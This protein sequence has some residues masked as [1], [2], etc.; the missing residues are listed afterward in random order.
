MTTPFRFAPAPACR[1]PEKQ[2]TVL[3]RRASMAA[4]VVFLLLALSFPPAVQASS[5]IVF[6][7]FEGSNFGAWK[8]E[9]TAFGGGPAHGPVPPQGPVC[10]YLG[11]GF[12]DSFHGG[13]IATGTLTSPAFK[14]ERLHVSFLIGGGWEK[15]TRI[16]L[17][18]DG[19][20]ERSAVAMHGGG[21]ELTPVSW[22]VAK[23][24]GKTA[25]IQ[26]VDNATGPWG[27]INVDQ[28]VFTDRKPPALLIDPKR[29][30][31][32]EKR[33]LY[34][35]L[36]DTGSRNIVSTRVKVSCEGKVVREFMAELAEDSPSWWCPLDISEWKG[37]KLTI[38]VRKMLDN[39]ATLQLIHQSEE[40]EEANQ[41]YREALRPQF[42]FTARRGWTND[43]NGMA[44][45][46]GEYHLF[47]QHDPFCR[48]GNGAQHWGHAVGKD[49]VHWEE[50]GDAIYP[51]AK[52]RIWSGSGV[53]D[54]ENTSGLGKDGK[55]RLVLFYTYT[56]G[57]FV[58]CMTYSTDGRTFT[59]YTGNPVV[60]NV[61]RGNRDPKVFWHEQTRSWI[62]AFYAP[63]GKDDK[64]V[65]H[66]LQLFKSKNLRDWK[67]LPE[68]EGGI[69]GDHFL[70]ECPDIYPIALDGNPAR[71]K[72]VLTAANDEYKIG[73]F[74][75]EKFIS[76]TPKLAG[77]H[78]NAFYAAQTFNNEPNGRRIQ[79]GWSV[80]FVPDMPFNQGMSV[81]LE[82][83]LR[84]TPD[85]PRL[86]FWPVKEIESLRRNP[87]ALPPGPLKPGDN[88][89]AGIAADA[90]D[91]EATIAVGK[92]K[93]IVFDLRGTTVAIDPS[94]GIVSCE[95]R[96]GPLSLK[97]GLLRLRILVDR[98]SLEIF[99]NDGLLFMPM[100]FVANPGNRSLKLSAEGGE[101]N[102]VS[103]KLHDM[104]G[105]W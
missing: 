83:S 31:L 15:E 26:I 81:P 38:E 75:G 70:A 94:E 3:S 76:E 88:P 60:K 85:G 89:L 7:D 62:M 50:L 22:N 5:D 17:L 43:P 102:I 55:P 19:K 37:R 99:A 59:K 79:I 42:H 78:G 80:C 64:T 51:D 36:K 20:A 63:F 69:G 61:S 52:G 96:R 87:Q 90:F 4:G 29:E 34:F 100:H 101:A 45:Y 18:V 74:D 95:D 1:I 97:D 93:R 33:W 21:E 2:K 10:G 44:Y 58:Q 24:A 66:T 82:V 92:A 57:D 67:P 39:A 56:N 91:L 28:I 8:T 23:L 77:N 46:N 73:M 68:I 16:D 104:A 35:P 54:L 65:R 48:W 14:I 98:M 40:W 13:E 32:A 84:G 105:I 27:H 41:L 30:I 49:L 103:L 72:W 11:K 25:R 12:A 71:T 86:A 6:A 53:V 9:G 47:F